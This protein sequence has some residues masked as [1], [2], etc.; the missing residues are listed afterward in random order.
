M[1]LVT[2]VIIISESLS[3]GV[4]KESRSKVS[5]ISEGLVQV[6]GFLTSSSV[7]KLKNFCLSP[8][9]VNP[10]RHLFRMAFLTLGSTGSLSPNTATLKL[11]DS[12]YGF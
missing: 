3:I 10:L 6:K 9:S 5:L 8:V 7:Y 2:I 12:T 4:V 11:T 1:L